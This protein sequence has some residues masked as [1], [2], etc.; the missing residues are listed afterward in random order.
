MSGR[1]GVADGLCAPAA[2]IRALGAACQ[3]SVSS[4]QEA[5]KGSPSPDAWRPD[6]FVAAIRLLGVDAVF[7]RSG[8]DAQWVG[9]DDFPSPGRR[10]IYL[11]LAADG[12]HVDAVTRVGSARTPYAAVGAEGDAWR[13]RVPVLSGACARSGRTGAGAA[14]G[15]SSGAPA[16]VALDEGRP[17]GDQPVQPVCGVRRARSSS[18]NRW[19]TSSSIFCPALWA[20]AVRRGLAR[21]RDE[22]AVAAQLGARGPDDYEAFRAE[23]ADPTLDEWSTVIGALDR[24]VPATAALAPLRHYSRAEQEA[25]LGL[26]ADGDLPAGL[27]ALQRWAQ[28]DLLGGAPVR[29]RR[30]VAPLSCECCGRV[31]AVAAGCRPGWQNGERGTSLRAPRRVRR[32]GAG[33]AVG[34]PRVVTARRLSADTAHGSTSTLVPRGGV[35]SSARR[36]PEGGLGRR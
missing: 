22:A 17:D 19:R 32:G 3:L 35:S 34:A 36:P 15:T 18:G 31:A 29:R 4:L 25:W 7:Y 30:A 12:S 14:A 2:F 20:L 13:A 21:E 24:Q 1:A 23:S 33:G 28:A 5:I 26:D 11:E 9:V 16:P 8:F 10:R 6:D 27:R